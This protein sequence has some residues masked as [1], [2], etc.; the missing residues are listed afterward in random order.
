MSSLNGFSVNVPQAQEETSDGY[1]VLK[2][3]QN[4]SLRLHNS[5]KSGGM[6]KAADAEVWIQ[7]KLI[8]TF[9]VPANQSIALEHPVNDTGKFTAYKNNTPEANQIGINPDSEDNGLIKVIWKPGSQQVNEVQITWDYTW[10]NHDIIY[11]KNIQE[12]DNSYY[13]GHYY[14]TTTD[15]K[16]YN[17]TRSYGSGNSEPY[18]CVTASCCTNDYLT[19]GGVGLS[20][21]SNQHFTQISE[22]SYDE[23]ETVIFLRIAFRDSEPRPITHSVYKVQ[24]TNVPKRL[25]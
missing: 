21:H 2:H 1:V 5:H 10:P 15:D 3:C 6:F 22:L 19:G 24:S 20:G 17:I 23:P 12:F 14:R 18:D 16:S 11:H 25:H 8:G 7:G 13:D 9:R 4:F